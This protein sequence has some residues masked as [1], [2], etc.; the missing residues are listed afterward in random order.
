MKKNL[1][2]ELDGKLVRAS[3]LAPLK[4]PE[5][6]CLCSSCAEELFPHREY[7]SS[8][9]RENPYAEDCEICHRR[10]YYRLYQKRRTPI[11]YLGESE[12]NAD[13]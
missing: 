5:S 7:K 2:K 8:P 4:A 11:V 1:P 10:A 13:G 6:R 9:D 3:E 12:G